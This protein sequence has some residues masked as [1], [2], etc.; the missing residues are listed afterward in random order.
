VHGVGVG[1]GVGVSVGLGGGPDCAQY[2]PPLF[3]SAGN[4]TPPPQTIISSPVH[5]AVWPPR[6]AGALTTLVVTQLSVPG[7]YLPPVL[8]R[9]P[10]LPLP[11]QMIIS[12]PVQT[13]L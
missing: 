8:N 5:T 3:P 4:E 1:V 13:A 2:L 9:V 7:L 11:P 12:L 6:P 10:P